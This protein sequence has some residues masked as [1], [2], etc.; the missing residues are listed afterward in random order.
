MAYTFKGWAGNFQ[1][2]GSAPAE[3]STAVQVVLF[4]EEGLRFRDRL[5]KTLYT[6]AVY[7]RDARGA[8]RRANQR[9]DIVKQNVVF[10]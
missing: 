4:P 2:W 6:L 3:A 8:A 1:G 7:A 5:D 10:V 9:Y